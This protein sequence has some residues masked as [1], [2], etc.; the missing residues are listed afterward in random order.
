MAD[1]SIGELP[2]AQKVLPESLIPLEQDGQAMRM[3]GEQF[4]DFARESVSPIAQ[5]A[6]GAANA[7]EEAANVAK[8]ASERAEKSYENAKAAQEAIENMEVQAKTLEPGS[9][10]TVEK[11]VVDGVVILTYGIPRGEQGIQGER[12]IQGEKGEK[13]DRGD[14]GNGFVISGRYDTTDEVQNPKDGENYYIGTSPPYDV[15]TYLNGEWVNGGLIQGPPGEPGKDGEDGK[16]GEDGTPGKNG[17]DGKSA[18]QAAQEGGYTGT[19][20]EFNSALAQIPEKAVSFSVTL[21]ANNWQ[22]KSQTVQN[23]NFTTE[24]YNYIVS[25]DTESYSGYT[26]SMV[27]GGDITKDGEMTFYCTEAPATDLTVNI[28]KIEVV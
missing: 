22:N 23:D 13:G 8:Y 15:Y 26:S 5:E 19:E 2:Q 7:A 18:Y 9:D 28:M 14:K 21:I 20:E 1:K 27:Y 16:P 25:P 6:T 24:G 11:D 17:I 4:A 10:V 12:G 3:T